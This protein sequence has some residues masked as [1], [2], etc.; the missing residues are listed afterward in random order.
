MR[1]SEL[2]EKDIINMSN[3]KNLGKIIDV[4][5]EEGKIYNF[6]IEPK[7]FFFSFF[8]HYDEVLIKWDEIN[9]IGEDVILIKF[10]NNS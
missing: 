7:R 9:T 8:R 3:G 1:L 5:V 10:K 4:T 2:Q 6:V